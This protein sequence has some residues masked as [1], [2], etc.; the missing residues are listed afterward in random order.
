[1]SQ[2]VLDQMGEQIDEATQRASQA[3]SAAAN[4]FE[5]GVGAVRCAAKQGGRVATEFYDDTRRRVQRHPAE[6]VAAT[7]AVG[8]AAGAA[9]GWMVGHRQG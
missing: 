1:M 6:T 9:I 2:S 7:F 4:A 5:D 8:V 3:A